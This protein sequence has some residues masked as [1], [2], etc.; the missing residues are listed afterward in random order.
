MVEN[1]QRALG[2]SL[3]GKLVLFAH[4]PAGVAPTMVI[5]CDKDGMVE[6]L[7]MSGKFAPQLF[8]LAVPRE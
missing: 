4:E 6:L 5:S 2:L 7:G 1:E 8:K 3:L